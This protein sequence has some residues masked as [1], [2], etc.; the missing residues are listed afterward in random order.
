MAQKQSPWLEGAYGWNFGEGGWNTGMDQNLIKFS[1]MFDRNIDGVVGSLPTAVDGQ[2][3]FLTTDNRFYF[4]V[5]NTWFS[6]PVPM[7]FE[8]KDRST[9]NTYQFNG[10]AAALIASPAQLDSRLSEVELTVASLGTAAFEDIEFFAT[11]AGL[12]VVEGAAQAYTDVLR[13]DLADDTDPA[14]G[15]ALVKTKQFTGA[16]G[17]NV[18]DVL[19][20][21]S[22]LTPADANAPLDGVTSATMHMQ[23]LLDAL[24]DGGILDL[25]GGTFR[26]TKGAASPAYPNNDQ[27]CL[28]LNGKSN[29]IVRNGTLVVNE[30]GQ[31]VFDL[32]SCSGVRLEELTLLGPGDFP[33]IDGMTGRAEKGVDGK[34]YF[35]LT[36]Y[37]SPVK[38]NNS[39]DTSE[40]T[41]G[42]YGGAFPRPEGGTGTTW[43]IWNGGFIQNFGY[44][45]FI[46][47]C[48][49][50]TVT[51]CDISGFNG[52]GVHVRGSDLISINKN[53]IHDN[54]TA[55]VDL[56]GLDG[57]GAV[58]VDD[59]HIY[60]NG[61]P[62]ASTLHEEI[63]PGYGVATNNGLNPHD[64]YSVTR[65]RLIGNKRK[66]VDS[67][68]AIKAFVCQNTITGSGIGVHLAADA[69]RR[70]EDAIV[71]DNIISNIKYGTA[72]AGV[73]IIVQS[74]ETTGFAKISGNI[75]R[76]VSAEGTLNSAGIWAGGFSSLQVS[77]NTI[78][79]PS[80]VAG[81]GLSV[82]A[83]GI[84]IA[85]SA[86][87]YGN[88]ITGKFKT[89][90]NLSGHDGLVA[91]R[92]YTEV[93]G[94]TI[95]LDSIA[96]L[97]Q[98][99]RGAFQNNKALTVFRENTVILVPGSD[100]V[101]VVGSA[102]NSNPMGVN[103]DLKITS[104]AAVTYASSPEINTNALVSNVQRSGTGL[105]ITLAAACPVAAHVEAS[106]AS[107]ESTTAANLSAVKIHTLGVG[108]RTITVGFQYIK[109]DGTLGLLNP[110]DL[111]GLVIN[112][113]ISL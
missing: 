64:V 72:A 44:G 27:P 10:T 106:F 95:R 29:V 53:S 22:V 101:Y 81:F 26:V 111:P 56:F 96:P 16:T 83:Q 76:D 61:H 54:Y 110:I 49:D 65:N 58:F 55:G 18:S 3:Y 1:F 67:H 17:R 33:P 78:L 51:G 37:N 25:S 94:N 31:S 50:V 63:D 109:G 77:D 36:L 74:T 99:G 46:S 104:A 57:G 87:I 43:G 103:L 93:F 20:G 107:V 11:Q 21:L 108:T 84:F 100:V 60:D 6:S 59:N 28:V 8:F 88:T 30:H 102:A 34:G 48:T 89:G 23:A 105:V 90:M 85:T 9:G 62:D 5:G 97:S 39:V 71:C 41:G 86:K 68:S 66:G 112:L 13:Q 91:D 70:L 47:G 14:K 80:V 4:A 35:D 42:G 24:P 7:W 79:N 75:I 45:V 52:T 32:L 15:A 82:P 2:A 92:N 98:V 19:R 40:F 38:R 73:G 69:T 12:D 113:R